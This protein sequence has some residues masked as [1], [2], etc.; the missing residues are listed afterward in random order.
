MKMHSRLA[1]LFVAAATAALSLSC[2]TPPRMPR[3]DNVEVKRTAYGSPSDSVLVYGS[4]AQMK[5][6][7]GA[8]PIDN[9]EMIQLNPAQKPMIITPARL[10]YYF[11]TE[12]LPRGFERQDLLPLDPAGQDDH[13]LLSRPPGQRPRRHQAPE[14]RATLPGQPRLRHQGLRREAFPGRG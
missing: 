3:R 5:F 11:F 8:G 9:L 13:V 2:M 14:A 1:W 6:L 10:G 7:F 12:P 4:A